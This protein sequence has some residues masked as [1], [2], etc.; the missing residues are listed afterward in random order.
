MVTQELG[1]PAEVHP[2]VIELGLQTIV[3]FI[4]Q[5]TM[6]THLTFR[7]GVQLLSVP[8]H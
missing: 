3:G 8:V 5:T 1:Q 6:L 7:V 2:R 4:L